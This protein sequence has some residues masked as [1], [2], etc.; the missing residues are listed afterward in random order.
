MKG[1]KMKKLPCIVAAFA[2]L[3]C[4]GENETIVSCKGD[5]VKTNINLAGEISERF[6]CIDTQN[7][8]RC[9]AVVMKDR[10][11]MGCSEL[12]TEKTKVLCMSLKESF[13]DVENLIYSCTL[14]S[15]VYTTKCDTKSMKNPQAKLFAQKNT[16]WSNSHH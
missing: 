4:N 11:F 6:E 8:T 10:G 3:G 1:S 2:L 12:E 13:G 5:V 9:S 14:N 16:H 7:K 15:G